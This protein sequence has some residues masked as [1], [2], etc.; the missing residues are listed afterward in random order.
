MT[1]LLTLNDV[2]LAYGVKPLLDKVKFTLQAGERVCLI[3]RN[4]AGKSSFLKLLAGNG[5]PDSGVVWKKPNLVIATLDQELPQH[6]PATVYEF[7]AEGLPLMGKLLTDYHHLLAHLGDNPSEKE[8]TR[9]QDLQQEIEN[10]NAWQFEQRIEAI[11]QRLELKADDKVAELSGGWQRRAAL[12]RA[13]ISAPDVLLL[14]E[15]SNHLDISAIQWLE[16]ALLAEEITTIF[17][18]HD[19][20]LLQ[21]LATRIIELDRGNLTSFPGDYQNFLVRK[22]EMLNAE[23]TQNALFDKKLAEEEKWIRQGVEARRTRSVARIR[24][25]KNMRVER[26]QR[27]DVLN[28]ASFSINETERSG[29]LVLEAENLT[30]QIEEQYLIRHFSLR[31]MRGDRIGLIGP[32]GVGKSTFL[33]I[34]LG[35]LPLQEG[36]LELG[37]KL[38][39]IYFD[40]LRETLDYDKNVLD[41]LRAVSENFEINGKPQHIMGYLNSFL[42]TPERALSPVSALSGGECNRLLLAR[43]FSQPSNLMVMDEPTND[44]DLETLELLEELLSDYQGTLFLVSHDRTFLDNVVTSTLVFEGEG[45]IQQYVGG[46]QDWLRQRKT[47]NPSKP[48]KTPAPTSSNTLSESNKAIENKGLSS[49]DQRELETLPKKIE[50]LEAERTTLHALI[51]T[52]DFY[53]KEPAFINQHLEKLK[54]LEETLQTHYHRWEALDQKSK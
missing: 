36:S 24:E 10:Q 1:P 26:S 53:Q 28:K 16:D 8:W 45:K 5:M 33:K 12:A 29:Q 40:Q 52:P 50:A 20:S 48:E 7:V 51:G 19:R 43:L 46:Y 3:G 54:Q 49:K 9:F 6:N 13:L 42:F 11:L 22:E 38:K 35:Q 31:V 41:N 23:S 21:R 18:T 32:N 25:L 14:D 2:S 34:L 15:P 47:A 30:F 37:T 44:L 39:I 27:R 17:I 4:G